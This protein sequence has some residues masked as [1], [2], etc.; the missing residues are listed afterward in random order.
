M[1]NPTWRLSPGW[2]TAA[3]AAAIYVA[4]AWY[5]QASVPEGALSSRE[6][7]LGDAV[8]FAL[9]Q[10]LWMATVT[11]IFSILP[12]W[13]GTTR[14]ERATFSVASFMTLLVLL[15]PREGNFW[16]NGAADDGLLG[17]PPTAVVAVVLAWLLVPTRWPGFWAG[18]AIQCGMLGTLVLAVGGAGAASFANAAYVTAGGAVLVAV[19]LVAV[20]RFTRAG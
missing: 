13:R 11:A 4:R 5:V 6:T 17:Y 18:V 16:A 3:L 8:G 9:G 12:P 15:P 2:S 14:W 10:L 20:R 7:Y 1:S 19:V